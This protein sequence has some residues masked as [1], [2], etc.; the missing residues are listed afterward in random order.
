MAGFL[1]LQLFG[2]GSGLNNEQLSTETK[3]ATDS[4][5]L[6]DAMPL[7]PV[8]NDLQLAEL[9][10]GI[11]F[12]EASMLY[13]ESYAS[14]VS[15]FPGIIQQ[16]EVDTS[17][18]SPIL[19]REYLLNYSEPTRQP[20]YAIT[21]GYLFLLSAGQSEQSLMGNTKP[22]TGETILVLVPIPGIYDSWK[23]SYPGTLPLPNQFAYI[24]IDLIAEIE[25]PGPS[26]QKIVTA[27]TTR[28]YYEGLYKEKVS[29]NISPGDAWELE[30]IKLFK[31]IAG[32]PIVVKG[33]E[34]IGWSKPISETDLTQRVT[35]FFSFNN[36]WD[37]DDETVVLP[38]FRYFK[39]RALLAGHPLIASL[40]R[41]SVR[42]GTIDLIDPYA[43]QG[44]RSKD[45]LIAEFLKIQRDVLTHHPL[46]IDPDHHPARLIVP[47][48]RDP[49]TPVSPEISF[50][51]DHWLVYFK[52]SNPLGLAINIEG[53]LPEAIAITPRFFTEKHQVIEFNV[54]EELPSYIHECRITFTTT[55]EWGQ[56]L[57]AFQMDLSVMG[58]RTVPIHFCNLINMNYITRM[59]EGKLTKVMSLANEILG[60]Q[61]NVYLYPVRSEAGLLDTISYTDGDLDDPIME[62]NLGFY[63]G[64]EDLWQQISDF[65]NLQ[66]LRI[67][68]V[69]RQNLGESVGVTYYPGGT[70]HKCLLVMI[71]TVDDGANSL[72][73][74]FLAKILVHEIGHWFASTCILWQRGFSTCTH[75]D[76]H[77]RHETCSGHWQLRGNI[78]TKH[79]NDLWI[80]QEQALVYN[81]YA[82]EVLP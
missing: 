59:D 72:K 55:D 36:Q 77:F 62:H 13:Y 74:N 33:G 60:R 54:A 38:F 45:K 75:G 40:L 1:P 3:S 82:H 10:A 32:V 50:R 19:F 20:V 23:Q 61:T 44:V 78:M 73:E 69:W 70:F 80:T 52:I 5:F 81:G 29:N 66:N 68:F 65:T 17:S 8:R 76:E 63:N 48:P 34:Q 57:E 47:R 14:Q 71:N 46:A 18:T 49:Q 58:F 12:Q 56:S 9:Y 43:I 7:I 25:E 2:C 28:E 79:E 51:A 15:M 21:T 31:T 24:N 39:R 67:V 22:L 37:S 26:L 53:D 6:A 30:Y 27:S 42:A 41:Q 64:A 16:R 4:S 35:M 11:E